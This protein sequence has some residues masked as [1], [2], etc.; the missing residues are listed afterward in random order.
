MG[1]ICV[2]QQEHHD[3]HSFE[4]TSSY[5]GS[6]GAN[7]IDT[8]GRTGGMKNTIGNNRDEKYSNALIGSMTKDQEEAS[9]RSAPDTTANI[10]TGTKLVDFA[11][12]GFPKCGTT[13]L[14][15]LFFK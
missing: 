15:I 13:F 4:Q 14:A 7:A 8:T 5:I 6:A 12:I 3:S 1:T 10:V 11:I 2:L 9:K